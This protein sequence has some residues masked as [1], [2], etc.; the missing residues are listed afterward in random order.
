MEEEKGRREVKTEAMESITDRLCGI[1]NLYF[2][3]ALLPHTTTPSLRK[4]LLLDLLRRNVPVF[5]GI[6]FFFRFSIY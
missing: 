6:S 5:L 3:Q 2:P 4:P 1:D